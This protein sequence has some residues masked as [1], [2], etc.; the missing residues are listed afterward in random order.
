MERV[1]VT[2]GLGFVGNEVVRRLKQSA[3]VAVLDNRNRV[4]PCIE[5]LADVP[6]YEADLTDPASIFRAFQAFEPER[7]V[8]LA[9]IHYIPECNADPERTLR[10][11]VEGTS[12]VLRACGKHR[13]RSVV[14][15]SSGAVYAD[16]PHPL[17]ESSRL[18][19]VDVYGWSKKFAEDLCEWSS[20]E[21]PEMR[22][23]AVRLFNTYGPRETNAH[24]I[25][26][27]LS[28]LRDSSKLS[29]GN[30]QTRRDFL[31]V[32][33]AA[34]GF[35]RLMR[36]EGPGFEVCNLGTGA[37]VTIADVIAV[38]GE[39]LVRDIVVQT[40]PSR[41]RKADKQVQVAEVSRLERWTG[42][43]PSV[44]LRVGLRDLLAFEGL[45]RD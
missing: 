9:A 26:E 6:V 10:V 7:V 16:S 12:G 13:V 38:L 4:A 45:L 30:I 15:A 36:L 28:Q 37:G 3:E 41:Y 32:G 34:E 17:G 44:T 5:D 14:V 33:D 39:L 11:N 2:G 23:T 40:D 22:V 43:R 18:G 42:W 25:P 1:L 8:H 24:I 27:V 21:H 19:P 35:I 29:L 31:H 20:R